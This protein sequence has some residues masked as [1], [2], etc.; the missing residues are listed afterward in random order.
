[1][2][3]ILALIVLFSFFNGYSQSLSNQEKTQLKSLNITTENLDLSNFT[4]QKKLNDILKLERKRMTNITVAIVL[5][6]LAASTVIF[7]GNFN[8]KD[9]RSNTFRGIAL[10]QSA[11][12]AA[13]T[14]PLWLASNKRKKERNRLIKKLNE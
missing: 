11:I 3:N 5:T 7:A 4:V 10:S 12:F 9:V 14:I 2:K 6:S 8:K 1:M 13:A